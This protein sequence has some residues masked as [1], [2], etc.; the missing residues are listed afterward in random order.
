MPEDN[1]SAVGTDKLRAAIIERD[2][3]IQRIRNGEEELLEE[4]Y[5]ACRRV[6]DLTGEVD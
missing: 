4:M 1:S 3:L 6:E 5:A 2:A